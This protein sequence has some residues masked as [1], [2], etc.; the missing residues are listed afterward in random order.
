M[1]QMYCLSNNCHK[2]NIPLYLSKAAKLDR[3]VSIELL[4]SAV[5][6][7]SLRT[8]EVRSSMDT[9]PLCTKVSIKLLRSA[10]L[11][12][13]LE[14][15][16]RTADLSSFMDTVGKGS[17]KLLRS[18]VLWT[19]KNYIFKGGWKVSIKLLRSAVLW[20]PAPGGLKSVHKTAEVQQFLSLSIKLLGSAVLSTPIICP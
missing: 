6:R 4:R 5:L 1:F 8:A 2:P 20:T 3:K 16:H 19:Q 18:A 17:I 15:V 7:Y 12:R 11:W 10:V 9:F 13:C 14:S